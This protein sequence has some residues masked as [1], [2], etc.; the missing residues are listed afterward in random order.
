MRGWSDPGTFLSDT[1]K[2][3]PIGA[4]L[5]GNNPKRS[6]TN[7]LDMSP[8]ARQARSQSMGFREAVYYH[9]TSAVEDFP[10]FDLQRGG[11]RSGSRAGSAGVSVS[12]SAAV[13]DEFAANALGNFVDGSRVLP[14]RLRSSRPARIEL[15]GRE[16]NNE[17]AATLLDAWDNGFDSVRFTNYTTPNGKTGQEVII[18][19]NPNQLR[20]VKSAA[21]IP[22]QPDPAPQVLTPHTLSKRLTTDTTQ[23]KPSA[24]PA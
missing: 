1:G 13:S 19:R 4:A 21:Q 20:S 15:T 8:A 9:G 6:K 14:L 11:A 2:P 5:T 18:V 10:A 23:N 7:T 3:N 12:P 17:V 16:T 22:T 24:R